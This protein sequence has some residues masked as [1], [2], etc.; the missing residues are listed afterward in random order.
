MKTITL[1]YETNTKAV[2]NFEDTPQV[3]LFVDTANFDTKYKQGNKIILPGDNFAGVIKGNQAEIH[4]FDALE[5]IKKEKEK[6]GIRVNIDKLKPA[7]KLAK[8]SREG[9]PISEQEFEKIASINASDAE[10]IE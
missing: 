10:V 8:N 4:N 2:L 3:K 6:Q 5:H 1:D 7:Y 9:R